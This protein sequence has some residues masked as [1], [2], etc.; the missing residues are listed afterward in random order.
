MNLPLLGL[1]A[2][3]FHQRTIF[4]LSQVADDEFVHDHLDLVA[5]TDDVELVFGLDLCLQATELAL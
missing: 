3:P 1:V 2:T 5:V 4:N